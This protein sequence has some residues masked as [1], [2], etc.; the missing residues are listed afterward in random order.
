MYRF[1]QAP[2]SASISIISIDGSNQIATI[3]TSEKDGLI[4]L[5]AYGFTFSSPTLRV[6]LSQDAVVPTPTAT[7]TPKS[8]TSKKTTITCIKG[9]TIKKVT[10]VNPKCPSGYKE[11]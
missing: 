10:A 8:A 11:K 3:A 1:T 7:V 9:K 4:H 2:I 5:G 6:K